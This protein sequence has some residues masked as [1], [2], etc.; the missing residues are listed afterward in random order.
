MGSKHYLH[1]AHQIPP[2][3]HPTEVIATLH[4]HETAL[5]LQA[6]TCGHTKAPSTSPSTLK[7]TYWYPPDQYPV[8]TYNV[9]ECITWFPGI[10][11]L[12]KK[13]ITFPS[14]FQDTRQGL[15][16]RADAAAGVTVRAEFRVVENGEAGSEVEGEGMGVGD[17]RWVLVED[18]EVTCAW[19]LMPFVKGKMEL[20]HRDVCRKIIDRV[21]HRKRSSMTAVQRQDS[22]A[23]GTEDLNTGFLQETREHYKKPQPVQ[24]GQTHQAVEADAVDTQR[25]AIPS[26][27]LPDKITYR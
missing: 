4:N 6:L 2:H 12:G 21:E 3:M 7:D 8:S 5:T 1:V 9:T 14:C 22:G 26:A 25:T 24:F 17:A 11:E 13:Y 18:V 19:Y 10:G 23:D 16:T 15:K 20:A 27:D